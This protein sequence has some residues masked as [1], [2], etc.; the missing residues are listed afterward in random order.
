MSIVFLYS[1]LY[2]RMSGQ[3]SKWGLKSSHVSLPKLCTLA[4][5]CVC[6]K[7]GHLSL[8]L[9]KGPSA[10]QAVHLQGYLYLVGKS[11]AHLYK[12]YGAIWASRGPA[13]EE[14]PYSCLS[15]CFMDGPKL[16]S[17]QSE[18]SLNF[19]FTS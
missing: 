6:L 4:W 15:N 2:L 1:L 17:G 13:N 11:F 14:I 3:G 19:Y 8:V 7:K 12:G 5:G 18:Y 10:C 16:K 9:I